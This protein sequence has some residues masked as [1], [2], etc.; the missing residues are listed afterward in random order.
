VFGRGWEFVLRPVD[1]I[2]L[3]AGLS[4]LYNFLPVPYLNLAILL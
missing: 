1:S 2:V 3:T 4:L